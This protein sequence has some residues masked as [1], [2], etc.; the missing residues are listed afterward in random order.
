MKALVSILFCLIVTFVASPAVQADIVAPFGT[1]VNYGIWYDRDGVSSTQATQWGAVNGDTYNTTG[2]YDVVIT[3]HA[4]D[5]TTATMFATING[6]QQGFYTAP[7]WWDNAQP[8][9]YPAGL[10][11]TGDMD[12][13]HVF[14][15]LLSNDYTK[16]GTAVFEDITATGNLG[17]INYGTFSY[18]ALAAPVVYTFSDIWDLTASDLILSYTADFSGVTGQD[19]GTIVF[20]I[21]LRTPGGYSGLVGRGWMGNV[22]KN[23]TPNDDLLNMNDK[24]DLQAY[25]VQNPFGRDELAYNVTAVPEPSTILLLGAGLAGVGLLRRRF[26]N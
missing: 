13:M 16:S 1:G 25:T 17:T 18:S 22:V 24:F 19:N 20:A 23:T 2:I 7:D 6:I 4:I 5:A 14:R 11:F 8:D 12:Q 26:K 15:W 3:Y 10:S 21:G 9:I